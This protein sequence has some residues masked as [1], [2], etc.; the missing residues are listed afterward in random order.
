MVAPPTLKGLAVKHEHEAL[1]DFFLS[2]GI[3]SLLAY[4][5]SGLA[6]CQNQYG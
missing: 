1:I 3:H 4:G 6:R 5:S 2:Q